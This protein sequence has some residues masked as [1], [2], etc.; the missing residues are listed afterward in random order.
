M[1][2]AVQCYMEEPRREP[3]VTLRLDRS[4][5]VSINSTLPAVW[6]AIILLIAHSHQAF[7]L[8]GPWKSPINLST[9]GPG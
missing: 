8:R 5:G 6:V 3:D 4:Y 9:S 2:A 1:A 7:T